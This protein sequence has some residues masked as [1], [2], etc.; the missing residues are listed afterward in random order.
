M[1]LKKIFDAFRNNTD[2]QRTYRE[3]MF[4]KSFGHHPKVIE[5]INVHRAEND[6]DIY[7]VF[8]LMDHDLHKIIKWKPRLLTDSIIRQITYEMLV[9]I[10]YLHSADVIHRDLKPANILL[11]TSFHVKLAD[12]GLSRSL[13]NADGFG[14]HH[15]EIQN[16]VMTEYVLN[17]WKAL[18]SQFFMAILPHS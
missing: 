18:H 5:L 3:I 16:P 4:L 1:A 12:F 2:A 9:G 8:P 10:H 15:Q 14:D 7:L 17:C 6:M 11:D 13:A